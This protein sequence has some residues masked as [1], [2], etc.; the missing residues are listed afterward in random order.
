MLSIPCGSGKSTALTR[1]ISEV[2]ARNDGEGLI[3]VTDSVDRMKEY[4]KHDTRNPAFDD[5]LLSFI[6]RHEKQLLS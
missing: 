5:V 2:L 6:K 4:W 3:I 1:L